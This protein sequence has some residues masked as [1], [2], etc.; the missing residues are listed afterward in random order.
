MVLRTVEVVVKGRCREVHGIG[1]MQSRRQESRVQKDQ[2]TL[3]HQD[4][5]AA[6]I[7]SKIQIGLV[8][9]SA[10]QRVLK[11]IVGCNEWK[12]VTCVI[13]EGEQSPSGVTSGSSCNF[14]C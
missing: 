7:L 9:F 12:L 3:P 8:C 10:S 2:E 11:T 6:N 1:M 4:R 5:M 13:R 14:G